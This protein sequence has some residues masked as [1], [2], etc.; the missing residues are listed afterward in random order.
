MQLFHSLL[1]FIES[2]GALENILVL[3]WLTLRMKCVLTH[4]QYLFFGFR[5]KVIRCYLPSLPF[6]PLTL[7]S[8]FHP[9]CPTTPQSYSLLQSY[10]YRLQPFYNKCCWCPGALTSSLLTSVGEL[11]PGTVVSI[12]LQY[13]LHMFRI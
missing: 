9:V 3:S 8:G 4:S 7:I 6:P 13:A 12:E 2:S 5:K 11:E 1:R 10:S